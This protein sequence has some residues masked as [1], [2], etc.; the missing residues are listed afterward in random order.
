MMRLAVFALDDNS[1]TCLF[2]ASNV[3]AAQKKLSRT[4]PTIYS[5]IGQTRGGYRIVKA[6]QPPPG[7]VCKEA[8]EAEISAIVANVKLPGTHASSSTKTTPQETKPREPRHNPPRHP[9]THDTAHPSSSDV[10]TSHTGAHLP[11]ATAMPHTYTYPIPSQHPHAVSPQAIPISI[12]QEYQMPSHTMPQA[13]PIP[14][15]THGIPHTMGIP[16]HQMPPPS[17]MNRLP[18]M[19]YSAGLQPDHHVMYHPG[20]YPTGPNIQPGLVFTYPTNQTPQEIHQPQMMY[21]GMPYVIPPAGSRSNT[22]QQQYEERNNHDV[23]YE[24]D[25]CSKRKRLSSAGSHEHKAKIIAKSVANLSTAPTSP[26]KIAI[27]AVLS[28][29]YSQQHDIPHVNTSGCV[30]HG[31]IHITAQICFCRH[32]AA[33]LPTTYSAKFP[34]NKNK[35]QRRQSK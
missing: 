1:R 4:R 16:H 6:D 25:R 20:M 24:D 17:P 21:G 32:F 29:A 3:T 8:K 28:Y 19:P 14:H 35:K 26:H 11:A 30:A 7:Y 33:T 12:P 10:E 13:H 34:K 5:W 15:H 23:P 31:F 27:T 9:D 2:I 22:Q 18:F